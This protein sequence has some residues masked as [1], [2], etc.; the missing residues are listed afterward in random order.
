MH[1]IIGGNFTD[2]AIKMIKEKEPTQ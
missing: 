1:G 2:D